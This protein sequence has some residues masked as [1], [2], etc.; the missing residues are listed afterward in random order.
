MLKEPL[1]NNLDAWEPSYDAALWLQR[2]HI[3]IPIQTVHQDDGN[4]DTRDQVPATPY[5][6]LTLQLNSANS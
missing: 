2:G 6:V 1:P 4:D 3:S 5:Q